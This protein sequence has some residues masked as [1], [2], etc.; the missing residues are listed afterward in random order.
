MFSANSKTFLE[1]VAFQ[2]ISI[3]F[4]TILF[5]NITFQMPDSI[6]HKDQEADREIRAFCLLIKS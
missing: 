2:K 3:K 4:S 5:C 6:A 1:F